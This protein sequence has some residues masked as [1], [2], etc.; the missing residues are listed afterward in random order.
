MARTLAGGR[1]DAKL[2][3]TPSGKS[4]WLEKHPSEYKGWSASDHLYAAIIHG[5]NRTR[6]GEIAEAHRALAGKSRA[7]SPADVAE[8]HRT[9][10][11]LAGRRSH[12]T[13]KAT[14]GK[15]VAQ[16]VKKA[17]DQIYDLVNNKY[18]QSIP[19]DRLFEIV[20][21]VGLR[22]DPEEE[23]FMLLGR[24]GRATWQLHDDAGRAV[25]HM[26]VLQWHKMDSTGRY[27]VVAYVS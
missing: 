17:N 20:R 12:A 22:F 3:I 10:S 15:Q 6:G 19:V 21:S 25:N 27:E 18:F 23:E 24:D 11:S 16:V 14:P 5:A 13:K 4:I 26:L 9:G 1:R 2:G 7:I 8:A